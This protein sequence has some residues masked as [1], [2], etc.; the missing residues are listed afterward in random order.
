VKPLPLMR[1]KPV[2]VRH[3][4]KALQDDE[5]AR[6][7]LEHD[8]KPKRSGIPLHGSDEQLQAEAT[9]NQC[10][11]CGYWNPRRRRMCKRCGKRVRPS[12]RQERMKAERAAEAQR[13][14]RHE[15]TFDGGVVCGVG[16]L[17]AGPAQL[18]GAQ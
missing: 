6:W 9:S 12:A 11:K 17:R 3:E 13:R 16:A 8:A 18:A 10:R 4:R 15:K 2:N 1:D 7:L 14:L 5:V